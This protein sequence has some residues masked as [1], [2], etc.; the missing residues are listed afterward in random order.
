MS[1]TRKILAL[2]AMAVSLIACQQTDL[3][4]QEKSLEDFPAIMTMDN[5]EQFV[6]APQSVIDHHIAQER[7]LLPISGGEMMKKGSGKPNMPTYQG[8]VQVFSNGAWTQM[9]HTVVEATVSGGNAPL[10]TETTDLSPGYNW[11]NFTTPP[12][13]TRIRWHYNGLNATYSQAEW[14][15]GLNVIDMVI[16]RRHILGFQIFDELREYIAADVNMDGVISNDDINLIGDLILVNRNDLPDGTANACNPHH[17]PF[18]YIDEGAYLGL[19]VLPNNGSGEL[20]LIYALNCT[21]PFPDID[22]QM[23]PDIT[24]YAIKRGDVSGSWTP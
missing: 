11:Q 23:M 22:T 18:F 1:I 3:S 21:L 7:V 17:Q 2:C 13:S 12:Q 19:D 5:W 24:A 9:E 4:L 15:S 8:W 16:I 20:L 6:E 10:F 14:E